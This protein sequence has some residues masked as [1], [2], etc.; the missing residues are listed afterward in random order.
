LVINL[1]EKSAA[2]YSIV[3]GIRFIVYEFLYVFTKIGI[4]FYLSSKQIYKFTL[5]LEDMNQKVPGTFYFLDKT[6][7]AIGLPGKGVTSKK[8]IKMRK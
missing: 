6:Y 2:I 1:I 8:D 7:R 3:P 4:L 5:S